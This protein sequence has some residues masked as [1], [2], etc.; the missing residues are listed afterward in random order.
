[1]S[2]VEFDLLLDAVKTAIAP[3]PE[4]DF[5]AQTLPVSSAAAPCQRQPRSP[6][7]WFRFLKAGTPPAKS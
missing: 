7:R 6:G 3:I 5:L 1:M 2:E 4:D